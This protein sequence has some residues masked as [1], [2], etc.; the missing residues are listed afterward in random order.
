[1]KTTMNG[2]PYIETENGD[3]FFKHA[4]IQQSE[5]LEQMSKDQKVDCFDEVSELVFQA[6]GDI[7]ERLTVGERI[8]VLQRANLRSLKFWTT[9]N[10]P[11]KPGEIRALIDPSEC[12]QYSLM[13]ARH[14]N[15]GKTGN[16]DDL[17][18]EVC[19][20]ALCFL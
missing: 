15:W 11:L 16:G 4:L 10:N 13:M 2:L 14:D 19:N 3:L 12:S 18:W 8:D 20:G 9:Y 7:W 17:D 5:E 1:M 6:T